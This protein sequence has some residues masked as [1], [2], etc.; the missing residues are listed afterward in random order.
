MGFRMHLAKV[1]V[2]MSDEDII[3]SQKDWDKDAEIKIESFIHD[4]QHVYNLKRTLEKCLDL[5]MIYNFS[6]DDLR[7]L[8][9][10]RFS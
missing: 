9:I 2:G 1:G 3:A 10:R 5:K 7:I 6:D 8:G 4:K